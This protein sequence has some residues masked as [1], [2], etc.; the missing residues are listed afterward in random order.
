MSQRSITDCDRCGAGAVPHHVALT[1][2]RT[3]RDLDLC[4]KCC[5]ARFGLLLLAL[6]L[7]CMLLP[8]AFHYAA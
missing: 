5:G 1:I 4:L 8:W 6:A 2:P 3:K 7:L